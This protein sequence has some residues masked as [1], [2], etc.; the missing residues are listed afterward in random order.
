MA[1]NL[2]GSGPQRH[3]RGRGIEK[4]HRGREWAG[5]PKEPR[6]PRRSWVIE[7][8]IEKGRNGAGLSIAHQKAPTEPGDRRKPRKGKGIEKTPQEPNRERRD[9]ERESV[10]GK[11]QEENGKESGNV[12]APKGAEPLGTPKGPEN[13]PKELGDGEEG[14]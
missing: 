4:A 5:A 2:S 7:R 14:P 13:A 10:R 6:R 3:R 12:A 9:G 1:V 11:S 8:G